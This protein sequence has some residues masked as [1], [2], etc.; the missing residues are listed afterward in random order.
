MKI[1]HRFAALALAVLT[2]T[3]ALVA[4]NSTT[5]PQET[6]AVTQSGDVGESTLPEN[7]IT[8]KVTVQNH[9]GTPAKDII[10]KVQKNG[11]DQAFNL[12]GPTGAVS[13]TLA[14]DDYTVLIESPSGKALHYDAEAAVL[15]P[16]APEITLTIFEAAVS[17]QPLNAPSQKGGDYIRFDAPNV[18]EGKTFIPSPPT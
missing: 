13:F 3:L 9:D 15:S 18:G 2:G 7:Q 12:I 5:P 10:V 11:A 17:T 1:F 14:E 4:C 16:A 8:Y 6:S